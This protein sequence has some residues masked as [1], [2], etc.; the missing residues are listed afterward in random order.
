MR[1][2][3]EKRDAGVGRRILSRRAQFK[4]DS[5]QKHELIFFSGHIHK[6]AV[7]ILPSQG[8]DGQRDQIR[9]KKKPTT[10]CNVK[11]KGSTASKLQPF[12]EWHFETKSAE[13]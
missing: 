13:T 7:V 4:L 5:R 11:K 2:E 3:R 6:K 12:Q 1:K 8:R 9:L 10:I